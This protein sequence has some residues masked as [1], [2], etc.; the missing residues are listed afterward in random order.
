MGVDHAWGCA[1][2]V[3]S[4]AA[5]HQLVPAGSPVPALDKDLSLTGHALGK[6]WY[7]MGTVSAAARDTMPHSGSDGISL[8][9][10][11]ALQ[12][13]LAALGYSMPKTGPQIA[14]LFAGN[15]TNTEVVSH[16][17]RCLTFSC[18]NV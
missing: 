13:V 16:S 12:N 17:Q 8:V 9:A 10:L 18:E 2:Q 15:V 14:G 6:A 1:T 5:L 7:A 11:R 3:H 4:P